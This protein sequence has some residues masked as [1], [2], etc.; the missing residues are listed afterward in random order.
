MEKKTAVYICTG[1]DIGSSLDVD[2]LESTANEHCDLC[3]THSALCSDEGLA[4]IK[5]DIE[6]EGVNTAVIAACSPRVYEREFNAL[7]LP[8][9]ERTN[10]REQVVWCH[11]PN[12]EDTQMLA[13]DAIIMSCAKTKKIEPP[14]ALIDEGFSKKI[15]V[16]GGGVS[17]MTSAIETARAGYEVALVEKEAE[18]GGFARKL[19]KRAPITPPY[20]DLETF[21]F[22]TLKQELEAEDKVTVYT[23]AEIEAITGAPCLFDTKI[24]QNGSTIDERF[25][26][27]VLTTG[28]NPYDP[29]KLE[30]LGFGKLPNVVTNVKMEE[31]AKSGKVARPSDE[32]EV[33][34]IVFVQCAG[35]RDEDHLSYCSAHCCRTSLKQ[36]MYVAEEN[37][38]AEIFV[39]HKDIRTPGQAEEFYRAAQE[40][41]ITLIRGQIQSVEGDDSSINVLTEDV[42]LGDDVLIDEVDLVVLATGLVPSTKT[43]YDDRAD[44]GLLGQKAEEGEEEDS[45]RP[46]ATVLNLGYRQ[47]PE[48][49]NLRYGFPDSHF[50]CFPYETRRTGIY[51]AGTVRRPGDIETSRLDAVGASLKAIQCVE[52][53]SK[54]QA[55]HPRVGDIS[56]PEINYD[57]CT[58]CK[59]C[60]EECPFGAYNEDEKANPLS[61]PSRCRRCGIC[62]GACPER[63][64]SF[65]NY[66]VSM[67]GEMLKSLEIPDEFDEKPR[68]L[69]FVCENDAYPAL[70]MVGM[71]RRKY[72]SFLRF[73]PLR[74]LG[75]LNLMWISDALNL[76]YD[77]VLLFGCKHG[78]DYQCHFVKGSELA[79]T[80]MSKISETLQ[81]LMLESERIRYEQ[82]NITDIDRIPA[83]IDEFMETIDDVGPNPFKGM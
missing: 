78:D 53:S 46:P 29:T 3:R 80:R 79:D 31:M 16:I 50:I 76:G 75:S 41:G 9:L 22:D 61:N 48:L 34:K 38:E 60:T 69:C 39:I 66:S 49:P 55:V 28:A 6:G 32:G 20:R 77:G 58:Q 8:L 42:L 74:C 37:P 63:V 11:E 68:V 23:G 36:A 1:C 2:E 73:V 27:V 71:K 17:G 19:H 14:E 21:D 44:A 7:D 13:Q 54:G 33:N 25:G 26:A 40:K 70:D 10:L 35:S 62:M 67:V 64:I 5:Q 24:K 4:L 83:I 81:R 51:A 15:L 56:Y 18:L 52:L 72:S 12:D 30:H 65:K 43:N 59:R 45:P 57:R 82:V 47:G